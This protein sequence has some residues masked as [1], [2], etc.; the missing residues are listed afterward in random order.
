MVPPMKKVLSVLAGLCIAGSLLLLLLLLMGCQGEG[1]PQTKSPAGPVPAEFVQGEQLFKNH[2][3]RCH[4]PVADGT[5]QGPP[6]VHKIYEPG[7][8]GD[9]SFHFAVK[10]GVRAHHWKFGDMPQ[11]GG[12][13]EAGVTAI[14]GYVRWLQREAGIS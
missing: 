9:G 5:Q 2:C 12:V 8:H 1:A 6:L 4:G 10:R 11:V 7:H 13:D 14:I 3:A